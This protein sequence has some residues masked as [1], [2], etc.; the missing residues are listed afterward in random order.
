[1]LFNSIEFLIFIIIFFVIYWF[2][3]PKSKFHQNISLLIGSYI[4]YGWWDIRFL[5][6]IIASTVLDYFVAKFIY[7]SKRDKNK[8]YGLF[9][10]VFFNLSLLFIFKYFNFFLD[11]FYQ[12]FGQNNDASKFLVIDIVLPVGISFYTFQTLSYT[13]DVYNKKIKPSNSILDLAVYVSFF[14]QLVAGPIERAVN[15]L[16]QVQKVKVFNYKNATNGLKLILIGFFK[17]LIIA[18]SFAGSV[19]VVF[20]NVDNFSY[21]SLLIGAVLFSFQIYCDFSGYTDIA[22]GL[23]KLLGFDLMLNFNF[24]YFSKTISEFWKRWHI[25]LSTWFRDYL[26]IPLG[27]SRVSFFLTLRNIFIIFLVSGLWHGA[28]W[29]FVVWGAIHAFLYLPSYISKKINFSIE[30]PRSLSPIKTLFI[31]STVTLAW[32]FFRSENLKIAIEY[33]YKIFTLADGRNYFLVK[34]MGLSLA[35]NLLFSILCL[36]IL[37]IFEYIEFKG[38]K[39]KFT[40]ILSSF[41]I[42]FIILFGQFIDDN[43]FIY[44]QF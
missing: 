14:P 43:M 44:F 20:S 7:A 42:I 24:P 8:N 21:L 40:P 3:I 13:I 25:S 31:F 15:F 35:T 22:R 16:P 11:S 9:L 2:I 1:M 32:I 18:D 29:T 30:F 34:N 6:L 36:I 5:T 41:V 39:I 10:S 37:L 26:Y 28:N 27:G 19:D 33:C 17:K 23:A 4:F 38:R 12:L